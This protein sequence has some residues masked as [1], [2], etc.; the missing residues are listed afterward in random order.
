ML[1]IRAF[2]GD[3][4]K[5]AQ[6]GFAAPVGVGNQRP[7]RNAPAGGRF[8]GILQ[9][10]PIQAKDKDI[11]ALFGALDSRQQRG[12]PGE[13]HPQQLPAQGWRR[14]VRIHAVGRANNGA[15]QRG[16]RRAQAVPSACRAEQSKRDIAA[17]PA[18]RLRPRG[19]PWLER[20]RIADQRQHRSQ[21]GKRKKTV[22]ALTR[23]A[24]RKPRLHQG[25]G[26]RQQEIWQTNGCSE[27]TEDQPRRVFAAQRLPVRRGHDG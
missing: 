25:T 17:G 5:I 19:N 16:T 20:E 22:G 1:A 26:C 10:F 6:L 11:D 13:R 9:L 14:L 23:E 12:Y 4:R 2:A 27:Q 3:D 18:V 8:Q 21:V 15:D 7:Y 24:A